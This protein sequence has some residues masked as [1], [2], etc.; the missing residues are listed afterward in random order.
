M[1]RALIIPETTT[2]SAP[3]FSADTPAAPKVD[4]L[5][6]NASTMAKDHIITLPVCGRDVRFT[7]ETIAAER[8]EKATVVWAGNERDQAL[9]TKAALDDLI[10]SFLASGQQNPAFGRKASG[11]IEVADGSRRRMTAMLTNSDYRILIGDLDDE[12]MGSLCKIGNDYRPTSAYERG[13][14]YRQRLDKEFNGNIS[15]LAESETLSRKVITRCINTASL[16]REIMALFAHP[17]ELSARAGDSMAK[18]FHKYPATLLEQS[19]IMATRKFN[20]ERL[21]A[22]AVIQQLTEAINKEKRVN[23]G[24]VSKRQYT[25]GASSQYKGNKYIVSIDTSRINA[26]VI[27]KIEAILTTLENK[28]A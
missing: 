2:A 5:I 9:L 28:P 23:P 20:G 15:S 26:D 3:E 22:D 18:I 6:S 13:K 8:V 4:S 25:V 27:E 19:R 21:E 11:T 17:G 24:P 10:P 14:R 7:L 16:P 1:K 12:Q